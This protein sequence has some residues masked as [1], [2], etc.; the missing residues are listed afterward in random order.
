MR[1]PSV[2]AIWTAT[3]V[4][5]MV[6]CFA[7]LSFSAILGKSATYDEPLHLVGGMVHR[8]END[9]RINPED[10]ALFGWWASLPHDRSA[11]PLNNSNAFY[12]GATTGDSNQQWLFVHDALYGQTDVNPIEFLNTSRAMFV[13]VGMGLAVLI[14][15]WAYQI[16]GC[17]AAIAAAALF[18]FDP[19]FLAHSAL[20]K[21]DVPLSL[22]MCLLGFALWKLGRGGGFQW[23][24]LAALSCAIAL[25]VK[26]SALLFGPML[27]LLL[28]ARA[29]LPSPW[30]IGN[31]SVHNW[32]RR[33]GIVLLGSAVTMIMAY[34]LTWGVY[35]FRYSATANGQPLKT[36]TLA[37]KSIWATLISHMGESTYESM[38][39]ENFQGMWDERVKNEEFPLP[40][41]VDLWME[42][43]HILPEGW[44]YGFLYT[45]A[46]TIVRSTYLLGKVAILGTWHYFP[47]AILFKTP[48]ATLLA[49]IVVPLACLVA[50]WLPKPET[51][52]DDALDQETEEQAASTDWWT[53]L[54]L[55]IPPVIYFAAALT[56]TFNLGLRHVL[57]IYPYLFIGLSVGFATLFN[58]WSKVAG[59]VGGVLLVGLLIESCLAYPDYLSFFNLF[60]GG[61]GGGYALLG[62]SNLDWG[63]DLP[64]LA[65]W[66]K[67]H[68]TEKLYLSYFGMAD[69]KA[70]GIDYVNLP[71]GYPFEPSSSLT[72]DPGVLA[73]S[74]TNLQGIYLSK[75]L[76][77]AYRKALQGVK[78][79]RILNRTIYLF[80]WPPKPSEATP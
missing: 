1:L 33:I 26:F 55:T 40:V 65:A 11:L 12:E 67:A 13:L 23:L 20:V 39:L 45:Y 31:F 27:V 48:S 70:Y 78:P 35:G 16:A 76:A 66:Q 6:A 57:P 46:T 77:E 34:L 74:A 49:A 10:P 71:G 43:H 68:P 19:N 18:C 60:S 38:P 50:W 32:R 5:V 58:R 15:C 53:L 51:S 44:L 59:I 75:Q 7:G 52:E 37:A 21:N 24:V 47:L 17:W 28:T 29:L 63:Q 61:S 8:Y 25:N 2:R 4:A 3:V 64:A 42:K 69:P 9:F 73:V 72:S 80:D 14:A 79:F 54:I 22:M 62:D 41:R 36:E 56:A 30:K